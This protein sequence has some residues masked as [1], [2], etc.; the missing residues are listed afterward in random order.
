MVK[1]FNVA[2]TTKTK[3]GTYLT[4]LVHT[5]ISRQE[6]APGIFA[7]SN[8]SKTVY[9]FLTGE[10]KVNQ[11]IDLDLEMWYIATKPYEFADSHT[12]ELI[13]VDLTY[14]YPKR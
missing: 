13:N 8:S 3:N 10:L 9:M 5:D 11:K 14:L 4:K 1:T 2:K 6:V 7:E 12:G